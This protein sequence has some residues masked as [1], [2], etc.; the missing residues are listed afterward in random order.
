MQVA[1]HFTCKFQ[2]FSTTF[3]KKMKLTS[4]IAAKIL[5][6]SDKKWEEK[7]KNNR[8]RKKKGERFLKMNLKILFRGVNYINKCFILSLK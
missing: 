6:L 1:G 5:G 3:F 4:K 8:K 2:N 7:M